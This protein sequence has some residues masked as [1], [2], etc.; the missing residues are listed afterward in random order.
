MENKGFNQIEINGFFEEFLCLFRDVDS[1]LTIP[2]HNSG[3]FDEDLELYYADL[4]DLSGIDK[5][6]EDLINNTTKI[7]GFLVQDANKT[8][9]LMEIGIRRAILSYKRIDS[10]KIPHPNES[11]L[12][13]ILRYLIV[14]VY[15]SFGI[16]KNEIEE[17]FTT[18]EIQETQVLVVEQ[19]R[20]VVKALWNNSTRYRLVQELGI[21]DMLT[22]GQPLKR[23]QQ[24]LIL[25]QIM[26]VNE[27]TAR[28]LINGTYS[29]KTQPTEDRELDE[30]RNVIELIK[31]KGV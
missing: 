25:S 2:K 24:N 27:D 26:G 7:D 18:K 11:R 22:K 16:C 29:G 30:L 23:K 5:R 12:K 4:F 14:E 1:Y 13:E 17:L 31:P 3:K 10:L 21:I 9:Q 6:L 28:N 19:Q 15:Q 8:I 20:K